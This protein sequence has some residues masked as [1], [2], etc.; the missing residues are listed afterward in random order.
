[1]GSVF[2]AAKVEECPCRLTDLINVIDHLTKKFRRQPVD[3]LVI[4]SQ[5]C[6]P[7][8]GVS[9]ATIEHSGTKEH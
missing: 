4:F 9:N 5:V 3:P 8:H 2:L 7:R 1:M 6:L